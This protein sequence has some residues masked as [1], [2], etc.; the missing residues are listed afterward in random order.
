MVFTSVD[1]LIFFVV[2]M[3][4]LAFFENEG[5]RTVLIISSAVFY[6]FWDWRFLFLLYFSV[7]FNFLIYRMIVSEDTEVSS[8]YLRF[9]VVINILILGFFK[10]YNFF[11]SSL[12]DLLKFNHV[13]LSEYTSLSIVL[14]VGISFFTFQAISFLVDTLRGRVAK[15]ISF[16]ELALY[17]TLFP[18]L[19]AGPIVRAN[20][21]FPQIRNPL[22]VDMSSL[23]T[24]S[25]QIVWGFFLKIC[26][27]NNAA[28]IADLAFDNVSLV[29]SSQSLIGLLA[30]TAQ[31]FG[32]FAGYSL[33]AIGIGT[34]LGFD[35][36]VNFRNPYKAKSF[37]DFWQ[38]WHIS[39]S[40]WLRDYLYIP[41]GG[42]RGNI[43]LTYR[44]LFVTM[45]LGGLWHGASYNFIIWGIL[46]GTFLC[47]E[48]A[49]RVQ[50]FTVMNQIAVLSY[51]G[52]CFYRFLVFGG[53]TFAWIF[54]RASDLQAAMKIIES[55]S[56]VQLDDF[57]ASLVS[58]DYMRLFGC[59]L[60]YLVLQK[61]GLSDKLEGLD[62]NWHPVGAV[63]LL[64][65]LIVWIITM[66]NFNGQTFIYF[67]F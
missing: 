35:F 3:G 51:L 36:G 28:P 41:L 22:L 7:V 17:I 53:V 18:Q 57:L 62:R 24:G 45:F 54:F 14:P 31:I 60:I 21:L 20:R 61:L 25:S 9:G 50:Q 47:V 64:S 15:D 5:K 55:I 46:H 12:Y 8:K 58:L 59:L 4:C 6:G 16:K 26:V 11:I 44:N 43:F 42:S 2:T 33:I 23:V 27:A 13:D 1:F 39:L 48:R 49:F 32:D 56:Q 34:L 52:T 38:R 65:T 66:G 19:V 67:Q 63:L 10:Y 37:S 40:S 29:T 30:F